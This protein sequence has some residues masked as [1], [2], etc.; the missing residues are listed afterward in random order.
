M[1]GDNV[2]KILAARKG[3]DVR[4]AEVKNLTL[5]STK[6]Q[7]K[8]FMSGGGSV[9]IVN[10][11][12][13]TPKKIVEINHNLGYQPLFTGWFRL[14]GTNDWKVIPAGITFTVGGAEA[15]IMGAIDRPNDNILQLHFYDFD[16][17]G[18][19]YTKS[20]DY[21][22]IIYIDPYKDAWSS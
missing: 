7:L 20:V 9:T 19:E 5:D 3:F 17:F 6:N 10:V 13:D 18:P 1:I 12:Y 8:E 11:A 14:N 22:Y 21:K 2:P 16:I 15:T 4:T